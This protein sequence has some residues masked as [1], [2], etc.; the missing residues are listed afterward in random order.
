MLQLQVDLDSKMQ[1][2]MNSEVPAMVDK[3]LCDLHIHKAEH[4]AQM[5]PRQHFAPA[6]RSE[7][8]I[9]RPVLLETQQHT[10]HAHEHSQTVM[11]MDVYCT[12]PYATRNPFT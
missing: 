3:T 7:A 6:H 4:C 12:Q 9:S 1:G 10:Q 5:K 2:D 8:S 11:D